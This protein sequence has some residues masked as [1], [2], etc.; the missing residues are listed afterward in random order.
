MTENPEAAAV[1]IVDPARYE[2]HNHLVVD[3]SN[4][5]P[6]GGDAVVARVPFTPEQVEAFLENE[7]RGALAAA[8]KAEED[9]RVRAMVQAHPDPLVRL[10]AARAGLA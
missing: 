7:R 8:A 10:L 5:T 3:V 9:A 6:K 2:P 1:P 4:W